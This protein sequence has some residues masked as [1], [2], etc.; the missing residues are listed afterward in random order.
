MSYTAKQIARQRIQILFQQATQIYKENPT[1]A[2]K[3]LATAKKIAMSARIRFPPA[4]KRSICRKCSMLM[5]PGETSRTR[6]QPRR[7][8]HVVVTCLNCGDVTRIPLKPK[9]KEKK[10]NEQENNN[11]TKAPR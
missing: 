8:H 10:N 4:A 3:Y 2:K 6:I 9:R 1:L 5:V 7:E 11:E